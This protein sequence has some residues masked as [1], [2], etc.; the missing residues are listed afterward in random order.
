MIQLELLQLLTITD[1]V[2]I[3][4][5]NVNLDVTHTWVGDINVTITSPAGTSVTIVDRIRWNGW[6]CWLQLVMTSLQLLMTLQLFQL[7]TS[8]EQVYHPLMEL[9]AQTTHLLLSTE[10]AP[11][12]IGSLQSLI[13]QAVIQERLTAWGI[14]Y[15]YANTNTDIVI[16]LGPDGTA[17]IDPYDII[18][19]VIEACGIATAAVDVTEV[20]CADIGTTIVVTA[21]VSD[22]SGNI[23]SCSANVTVVDLLGS[24]TYLPSRSNC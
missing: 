5:L 2:S 18:S 11:W 22:T 19:G 23:A 15:S 10:K 12:V 21:F 14:T 9:S 8:V 13:M 1:D 4:D 24:R 16:E 20:S 3:D 7:K 17:T 6:W